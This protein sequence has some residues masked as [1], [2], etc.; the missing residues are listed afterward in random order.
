MMRENTF[1]SEEKVPEESSNYKGN[2]Y[3]TSITVTKVT[4]NLFF[5]VKNRILISSVEKS[6]F[7]QKD[8]IIAMGHCKNVWWV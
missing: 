5:S 4:K 1:E 3:N 6:V 7:E 8:P 2:L